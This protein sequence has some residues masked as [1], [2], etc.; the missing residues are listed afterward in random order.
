MDAFSAF[1]FF[2]FIFFQR[3]IRLR[4]VSI[5]AKYIENN[6][7]TKSAEPT[8]SNVDR[9]LSARWLILQLF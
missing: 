2:F 5:A 1:F 6:K 8:M 7:E 3:P 9:A 4:Y